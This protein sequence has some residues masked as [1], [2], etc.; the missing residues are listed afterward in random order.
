MAWWDDSDLEEASENWPVAR[1]P[2]QTELWSSAVAEPSVRSRRQKG[3]AARSSSPE[4][5]AHVEQKRNAMSTQDRARFLNI[6]T[7]LYDGS[8]E[9]RRLDL[10]QGRMNFL[11]SQLNTGEA[12]WVDSR[13][14]KRPGTTASVD[15]TQG[16]TRVLG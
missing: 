11:R 14:A 2:E 16:L 13:P 10:P 12:L 4:F 1:A 5:R 3:E 15:R 9:V 6:S 7:A 8:A